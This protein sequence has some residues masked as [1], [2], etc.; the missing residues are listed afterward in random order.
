MSSTYS[1]SNVGAIRSMQIDR[2]ARIRTFRQLRARDT[3]EIRAEDPLHVD[4]TNGERYTQALDR[5]TS[6]K[7][8]HK[9][10]VR[11][12]RWKADWQQENAQLQCA[13]KELTKSIEVI[14]KASTQSGGGC[15][16]TAPAWGGPNFAP[17]GESVT[18]HDQDTSTIVGS[19]SH[20]IST[21]GINVDLQT[22][23]STR[24]SQPSPQ[25]P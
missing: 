21:N 4:D 18:I 19:E 15:H 16:P 9:K 20:G 22:E 1:R 25:R 14:L 13:S 12:D 11:Q 23:G 3:T 24:A 5:L 7:L 10:R 17:T 8:R 6:F 2:G